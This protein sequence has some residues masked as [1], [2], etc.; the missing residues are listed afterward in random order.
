MELYKT[1]SVFGY[2]T[3]DLC[4]I[5]NIQV[6]ICSKNAKNPIE[7]RAGQGNPL[8]SMIGE[9]RLF[10]IKI[11]GVA[12]TIKQQIGNQLVDIQLDNEK[13]C[14]KLTNVKIDYKSNDIEIV[15]DKITKFQNL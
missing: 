4:V 10:F 7:I 3:A 2:E 5:K 15:T 11:Y 8:L 13:P 9:E 6:E 12:D 1:L 14:Y